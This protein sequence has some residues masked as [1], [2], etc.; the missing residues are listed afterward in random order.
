MQMN[1]GVN[2]RDSRSHFFIYCQL[3]SIENDNGN[4]A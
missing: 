4:R 2:E 3:Q 1:V